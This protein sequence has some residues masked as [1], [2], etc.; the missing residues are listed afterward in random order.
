MAT[1]PKTAL[2]VSQRSTSLAVKPEQQ[3]QL[4]GTRREERDTDCTELL[5]AFPKRANT[6]IK[7]KKKKYTFHNN[8][9]VLQSDSL[10][11]E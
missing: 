11:S 8:N 7:K 6:A 4:L 5:S 9:S 3:T 1:N 10:V 2:Q